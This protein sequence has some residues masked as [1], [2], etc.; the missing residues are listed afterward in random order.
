MIGEEILE[1]PMHGIGEEKTMTQGERA[2]AGLWFQQGDPVLA[3]K[4]ARAK[5]LCFRLNQ[6]DPADEKARQEI[7]NELIGEHAGD[8]AITSPFYCDYGCYIHVGERFFM[9]YDCKILDGADVTFGD[10]VRIGPGCS[11]ITANHA[12]DPEERKNG[13]EIFKPITVG[14]NVWFGANVTVLPGVTIGD[15][16]VIAAGSVV[17]RDIPAG[18]LAAGV[19][20]KVKRK[21]DAGDK[22]LPGEA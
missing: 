5:S 19:P 1:R 17:A 13:Y 21:L 9:N 11:F 12:P 4:R 15:D 8:F 20:C 7:L 16:A 18:V 10:D 6:T 2:R 14:N 3:K 22:I